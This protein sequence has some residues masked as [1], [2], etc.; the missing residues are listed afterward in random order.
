MREVVRQHPSIR[1]TQSAQDHVEC[2]KTPLASEEDPSTRAR[3]PPRRI[4]NRHRAPPAE[5]LSRQNCEGTSPA[6][7]W[8]ELMD[9]YHLTYLTTDRGAL[10]RS[11]FVA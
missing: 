10:I 1:L 2:R 3:H 7:P 5:S 9:R 11:A 6:P 4:E 8:M